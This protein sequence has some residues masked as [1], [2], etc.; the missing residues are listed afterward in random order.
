MKRDVQLVPIGEEHLDAV[1][2]LEARCFSQPWSRASLES[3]LSNPTARFFVCLADGKTVGHA[4][5]HAVCGEGYVANIAVEPELRGRGLGRALLER[6]L[7]CAREEGLAFLTLEVR[8]S[9]RAAVA[10]YESEGFRKAGVR[11]GFYDAPKE[12]ALLMTRY[13]DTAESV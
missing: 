10:L 3:E 1:A 13:L 6:L 4:G 8:P 5:M 11:R 12:D 9:N 2:S 7:T